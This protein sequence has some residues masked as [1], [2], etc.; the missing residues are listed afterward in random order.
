MHFISYVNI[1]VL[2]NLHIITY[3]L[4]YFESVYNGRC[5]LRISD[6]VNPQIKVA[7]HKKI[8]T[9]HAFDVGYYSVCSD[10][11]FPTRDMSSLAAIPNHFF[12]KAAVRVSIFTILLSRR[13]STSFLKITSSWAETSNT[14]L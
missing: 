4:L 6:H 2:L 14:C 8:E 11:Q 9:N 10:Y 1:T 13:N 12:K 7:G 3:V 5:Y